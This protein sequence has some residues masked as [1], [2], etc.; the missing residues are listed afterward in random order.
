M[1][2]GKSKGNDSV[3]FIGA[4]IDPGVLSHIFSDNEEEKRFTYFKRVRLD[5]K[6]MVVIAIDEHGSEDAELRSIFKR[7]PSALKIPKNMESL[8]EQQIL[9]LHNYNAELEEQCKAFDKYLESKNSHFDKE[10]ESL[11]ISLAKE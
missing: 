6:E 10:I 7:M 3:D 8:L 9:S 1:S 11:A 2:K 4:K 5:E